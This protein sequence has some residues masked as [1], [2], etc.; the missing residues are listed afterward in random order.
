VQVP[1]AVRP[2]QRI[3]LAGQGAPGHGGGAPGDLFLQVEIAPHPL[4]RMEGADLHT[5]LPVAAWTAALGGAVHLR[6]LDGTIKVKVPPGSSSGRRI[7]IAGKGFPSLQGAPGDLYAEIR[8][9]VPEQAS[10]EGRELLE[11]WAE[12][13]GFEPP[14]QH[15]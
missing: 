8:I 6:T 11:K 15:A 2:G 7:R 12:V 1:R 13:S 9:H 5:V 4:F 3:R 10:P 14:P